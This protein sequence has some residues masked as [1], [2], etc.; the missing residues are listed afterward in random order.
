[1]VAQTDP[2]FR[3]MHD[4]AIKRRAR[5]EDLLKQKMIAAS[6]LD[7][8]IAQES[9][10]EIEYQ[11]HVRALADFPNRIN[12]QMAR[13]ERSRSGTRASAHRPR[14]HDD[15]CAVRRTRARGARR[16]RQPHRPG[17]ASH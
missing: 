16:S 2:Q 3:A 11:N 10:A 1:M 13:I 14:S 7:E 17:L 9:A 5:H 8:A 4:V 15:S 12:E 6:L